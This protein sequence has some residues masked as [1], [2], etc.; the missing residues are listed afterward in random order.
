VSRY[1]SEWD[2]D[3]NVDLDGWRPYDMPEAIRSFIDTLEQR[4]DAL[5]AWI[6]AL[7]RREIPYDEYLRSDWWQE[8]RLHA[9]DQAGW[10]CEYHE[11]RRTGR[12][13]GAT[14]QLDV[15]HL[16]YARIGDEDLDELIVLCR[17]HHGY[18]HGKRL[19]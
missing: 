17:R 8:I 5:A 11:W 1:P 13:C 18:V 7:R 6:E 9:L 4:W 12:R 10:R 3:L 16:T 14:E 2:T 15:H 19:R